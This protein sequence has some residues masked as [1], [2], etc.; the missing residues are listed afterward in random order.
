MIQSFIG[1]YGQ[2][3]QI[4]VEHKWTKQQINLIDAMSYTQPT[5]LAIFADDFGNKDNESKGLFPYKG[6]TYEN[7]NQQLIKLQL[8]TIKAFDSMLKN[9]TM[10]GDDYLQYLSD[11]KNYATRWDYLQHYNELETQIMIQPLDNLINWFYQYNVDMLSF[12]DL[13]VN[14]NT[15]K[16]AESHSLSAIYFPTYF[17]KPA[18]LT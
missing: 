18:Q 14:A 12:M 7:Y 11:A 5:D 17:A 15:I 1:S 4:V 6:I 3:K 16:Y 9:K 2:G 10:T 8:F 13:A